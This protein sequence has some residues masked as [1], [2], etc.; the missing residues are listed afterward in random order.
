MTPPSPLPATIKITPPS[1]LCLWRHGARQ[2]ND[3]QKID[4]PDHVEEMSKYRSY[5]RHANASMLFRSIARFSNLG[6]QTIQRQAQTTGSPVPL[7]PKLRGWGWRESLTTLNPHTRALASDWW[8]I[9][10]R[11]LPRSGH[12]GLNA[13]QTPTGSLLRSACTHSCCLNAT[14]FLMVL[15]GAWQAATA[16]K[17][18]SMVSEQCLPMSRNPSP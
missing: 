4:L 13:Y 5:S 2:I 6:R 12:A 3:A 11:N 16:W 18:S 14:R 9:P 7:N 8:K 15:G 17:L 10:R 1:A